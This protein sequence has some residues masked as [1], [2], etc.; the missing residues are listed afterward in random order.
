MPDAF[1]LECYF[2]SVDN[3]P[4]SELVLTRLVL[5]FVFLAG[6]RMLFNKTLG[7][8]R[9]VIRRK[10]LDQGYQGSLNRRTTQNDE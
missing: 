6:N 1:P 5:L 9:A 10:M 3:A 8:G 4:G 7:C 2:P